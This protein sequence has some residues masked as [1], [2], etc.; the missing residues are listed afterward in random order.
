MVE[1]NKIDELIRKV[2]VV[3]RVFEERYGFAMLKSFNLSNIVNLK[4]EVN[5]IDS[6]KARLTDVTTQLI[7][8]LNKKELD[9]F[10]KSKTKGSIISLQ[11]FLKRIFPEESMIID[12]IIYLNLWAVYNVRTEYAH[13]KNR[14]F[15]KA[16]KIINLNE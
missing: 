1:Q 14:N 13:I 15:N 7:E 10:C 6:L 5:D 11:E 16:L 4:K 12:D 8:N 3:Q 9:Q 2:D